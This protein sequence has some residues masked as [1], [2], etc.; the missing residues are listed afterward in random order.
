MRPEYLK[1]VSSKHLASR[2][3]KNQNPEFTLQRIC[4]SVLGLKVYLLSPLEIFR[5]ESFAKNRGIIP[6]NPMSH[7]RTLVISRF[8]KIGENSIFHNSNNF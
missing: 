2:H 6:K 1:T 8:L 5:K 3:V 7:F 4:R